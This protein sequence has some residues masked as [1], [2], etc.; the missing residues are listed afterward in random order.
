MSDFAK[1]AAVLGKLP[2]AEVSDEMAEA[3][4]R[5]EVGILA[6]PT[7]SGKSLL[8]SAKLA[9]RA[10][11]PIVVLMPRRLLA[12]DA[13]KNIADMTGFELGKE[14]GYALGRRPQDVSRFSED[15]KLLFCTYGYALGSGLINRAKTIVLDEAHEKGEAISLAR[16]ILHRRK[17]TE[18][19]L[20]L[21]EMSAT[22]NAERQAKYWEDVAKPTLRVVEKSTLETEERHIIPQEGTSVVS[23]ATDL[24]EEGRKGIAIFLPGVGEV[25]DVV[26]SLRE[27]CRE[28]GMND[29][30]VCPVYSDITE[31]E[32]E[33]ATAPPSPGHR[34]IIV[35]TNVI[36]SGVNLRWVDAGISDGTG[37][38]P[39]YDHDTGAEA[40]VENDL[41]QW[42]IV[43]Q[44]GRINRDPAHSGF[45]KGIFILYAGK[46]MDKRPREA[47]PELERINPLATIFRAASL[48]LDPTTLKFDADL[49]RE[50]IYEAR[51]ALH[52]LGLIGEGW[53]LTDD[54]K[55]AAS[56]PVSPEGGA[57]LAEAQR[58]EERR[59]CSG[60]PVHVLHDAITLV[61]IMESG[62]LRADYKVTHGVNR[63]SDLLDAFTAYRRLDPSSVNEEACLEQNISYK[64]YRDAHDLEEELHR[65]LQP[66]IQMDTTGDTT[67]RKQNEA[68]R[69]V[70]LHG[71][72]NRLF[73]DGG[74]GVRDLLRG[75][76]GFE[77]DRFTAIQ[78]SNTPLVVGRL[79]QIPATQRRPEKTILEN[80]TRI[81]VPVFLHWAAE[82]PQ[83]VLS[84][85]VQSQAGQ[86]REGGSRKRG[87]NAALE[88]RHFALLEGDYFGHGNLALRIT[89]DISAT[90]RLD[91]ERLLQREETRVLD[92]EPRR[93]GRREGHVESLACVREEARGRG[94]K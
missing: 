23:L 3:V 57:M 32:R 50:R 31:M 84:G 25:N 24:L 67:E 80:M 93:K 52:R 39:F 75:Q 33:A 2:V 12:A 68:L 15:T 76:E 51:E 54:G 87:K 11:D 48:G 89:P 21:L 92:F 72:V 65:R 61:A 40:L 26:E 82:H 91:I 13:A 42:R 56:L 90:A 41:P 17:R 20:R 29:V 34:K 44:R 4:E 10:S 27:V 35:G 43:Q 6:A 22:V 81:P 70:I 64:R 63:T 7:G 38:L 78:S 47:E 5:G 16:A 14:V 86:G 28:K 60:T 9:E 49:P 83:T 1:V 59:R 71:G 74:Q 69:Q 88:R 36:E 18:P 79:R 19:D 94:R 66:Q 8:L 55:L 53:E 46:P 85:L 73:V 37:K 58:M 45:N 77:P 30:E 62:G